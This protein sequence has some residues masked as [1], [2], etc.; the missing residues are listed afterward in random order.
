[1]DTLM[2]LSPYVRIA[3]YSTLEPH[4]LL[5]PRDIFDYELL[6]LKEGSVRITVE[7]RVYDGNPGDVFLFR[8]HQRHKIE[9][10]NN[11]PVIQ[12][13]VHFD[14]QYRADQR[15]VFVSYVTDEEMTPEQKTFFRSDIMDRFYPSIPDQIHLQNSKV[16]EEYLFA[17]IDEYN[18]PSSFTQVRQQWYF[19][20]LFDLYLTEV[21]YFLHIEGH[22]NAENIASRMKLYLDNNTSRRVTLEELANV[23][24]LDKSYIIRLFRQFYQETPI[25][26]HQKVRINRAKSMLLYTNLSVTE[27]ASNT[28]FSSIHDFDRVFRKMDGAAPSV[29]RPRRIEST[30]R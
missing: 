2:N 14:L 10:L 30:A 3:W 22:S 15:D 18:M 25:S 17:L 28:G 23:V 12:P 9:C 19:M 8:P 29:Y 7:G 20:R 21:G 27:I 5:G 26:Y 16:F 24:H 1:M 4:T 11:F 13:H 6:Y